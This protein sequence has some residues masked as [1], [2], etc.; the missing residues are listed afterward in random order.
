MHVF[1]ILEGFHNLLLMDYDHAQSTGFLI[2]IELRGVSQ[3]VCVGGRDEG[4]VPPLQLQ[5]LI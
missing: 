1:P 3:Y 4:K 2:S 5:G